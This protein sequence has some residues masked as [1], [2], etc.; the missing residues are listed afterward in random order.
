VAVS[1][2]SFAVRSGSSR[3]GFARLIVAATLLAALL[4]VPESWSGTYVPPPH[5]PT[6]GPFDPA[7]AGKLS[8]EKRRE[9]D[10][11]F[12][13]EMSLK[14]HYPTGPRYQLFRKMADDGF[15]TAHLA[16]QLFDIRLA[17]DRY[18][19][20]A[21]PRLEALAAT[22]DSSAMCL[23]AKYAY[24]FEPTLDQ[25]VVFETVQKLA[26]AGHPHCSGVYAQYFRTGKFVTPS[27]SE[28]VAWETKAAK[29]GDLLAQLIL[30]D[31]YATG[32]GAYVDLA[33]ARC[34]LEEVL[35]TNQSGIV[36]ADAQ[37]IRFSIRESA[38]RG[39]DNTGSYVAG[40][41]C[42]ARADESR[43]VSQ[44]EPR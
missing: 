2:R 24:V 38:A 6:L 19:R 43:G 15:E 28:Y 30:A 1:S 20:Q 39:F 34:W 14:D 37:G 27:S 18:H 33:R 8:P 10:V 9:Y 5:D 25:R 26:E 40:T 17:G 7:A 23:R 12:F 13:N 41:G 16:L 21:W 36:L 4:Y 29:A 22:G 31:L 3:Q 35:R 42:E 32:V 44:K 11:L